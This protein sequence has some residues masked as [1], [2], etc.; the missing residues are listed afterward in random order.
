MQPVGPV[1]ADASQVEALLRRLDE[2]IDDVVADLVCTEQAGERRVARDAGFDEPGGLF[3]HLN[4]RKSAH[5]CLRRGLRRAGG[6]GHD[7]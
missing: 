6:E 5:S 4:G 3:L 1:G 2:V 7:G